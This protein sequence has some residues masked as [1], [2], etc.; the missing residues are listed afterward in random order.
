ML[1]QRKQEIVSQLE[2]NKCNTPLLSVGLLFNVVI[3]LPLY[4]VSMEYT[5]PLKGGR[6][7]HY[8]CLQGVAN[9]TEQS[10]V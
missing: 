10:S 7:S 9:N 6:G 3:I 2:R 5:I 4:D 8:W 1:Q